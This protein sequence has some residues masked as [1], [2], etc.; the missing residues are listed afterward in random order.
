MYTVWINAKAVCKSNRKG[1]PEILDS[2][3]AQAPFCPNP[4]IKSR[5]N[6]NLKAAETGVQ[7][8]QIV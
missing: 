6:L 1:V 4:K 8:I 3:Q 7:K 5:H 2:L